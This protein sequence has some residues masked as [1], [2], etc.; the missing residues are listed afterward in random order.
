MILM[1]AIF[2]TL[3]K[4]VESH[5]KEDLFLPFFLHTFIAHQG[6]CIRK[7]KGSLCLMLEEE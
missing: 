2:F 7:V 6:Q 3:A 4:E 5:G 1:F